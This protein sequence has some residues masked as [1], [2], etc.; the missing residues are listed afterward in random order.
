MKPLTC[1]VVGLLAMVQIAAA[2]TP[3][4]VG[5]KVE[6]FS[7]K[8]FRGTEHALSD[9]AKSKLV[10]IAFLGTECPVAKQYGPRLAE[11]AKEYQPRGVTFLGIN[12]N[13][14][15]SLTEIAAYAR[16]S[17][18]KF[19]I[20]KDLGNV[21]ADRL[22]AVRTP[23]VFVLDEDRVVRYWGRI[24]D[25]LGVG[26]A[27]QKPASHYLQDAIDRL[28]EGQAVE[29]QSVESVGCH[30][31]RVRAPRA[32]SQLTYSNQIARIFQN[33]CVQCHRPGEI[34]PFAL[35]D[36][37]EVAGWADTI[38]E[39]VRERR[40]PPWHASREY[41]RF[42]NDASLSDVEQ[43]QI[44]QWAAAGAPEGDPKD[45]PE[46]R[47]FVEGWTLPWQPDMVVNIQQQPFN[48]PANGE[49][50][51]QFF[52]VDPGF[53]EDKWI[54]ASQIVPGES[55][56]VHHVLCFVQP[57]DG[58]RR[59]FDENG[60]GF[61]SAYVPGYR[62]APFPDGMAKYVLAGSKLVFQMH[63]T[64]T[65]KPVQDLSRIGF[66]FARPA[67][68]THMIQTVSTANRGIEIPSRK[69]DYR[70]EA[71]M[72][73]YKNDLQELVVIR[74]QIREQADFFDQFG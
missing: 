68:L 55:S 59:E 69:G 61:L 72:P 11:L 12:A 62:A 47:R 30:I 43:D 25:R 46:P 5:R 51:Y 4:P 45:L 41:G 52:T 29:P 6:N 14:Q 54:R 27:R 70:A 58:N 2:K 9:A 21:V 50:R 36:Y 57:K 53:T 22:G 26:Y 37:S 18:I 16:D 10:V 44:L 38:A 8:D 34:A 40:M 67:E 73:A 15:D 24:D 19:P 20:L 33:R 60:L 66:V 63:Y 13:R 28:L 17:E 65:G 31:G 56:V 49:L 48:V 74:F 23:E 3:S 32:D 42:K 39:V 35:T 1:A 64:P 71:T 7:L